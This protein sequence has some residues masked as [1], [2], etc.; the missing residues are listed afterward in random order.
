MET[1]ND[2]LAH[3]GIK[4]MKWDKRNGPPYPL[5]DAQRSSTENRLNPTSRS[6]KLLQL[7]RARGRKVS[8]TGSDVSKKEGI[9]SDKPVGQTSRPS[10]ASQKLTNNPGPNEKEKVSEHKSSVSGGRKSNVSGTGSDVEKKGVGGYGYGKVGSTP[11]G[12]PTDQDLPSTNITP[13]QANQMNHFEL[14]D[15]LVED[16]PDFIYK[17]VVWLINKYG[18]YHKNMPERRII[19]ELAQRYKS[20]K[21]ANTIWY[22][23]VTDEGEQ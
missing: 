8:G 4:G 12:R 20:A 13:A 6:A 15:A 22:C 21:I 9:G 14:V 10:S 16:N 17:N 7:D 18:P 2:W 11:D 5:S 23:Y 1:Y 19:D 3:H